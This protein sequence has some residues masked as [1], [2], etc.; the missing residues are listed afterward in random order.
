MHPSN[1]F[2]CFLKEA[3]RVQ[4]LNYSSGY[5]AELQIKKNKLIETVFLDF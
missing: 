3:V 2:L 5:K 1:I 4:C